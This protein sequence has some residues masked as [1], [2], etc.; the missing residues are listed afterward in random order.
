MLHN[1]YIQQGVHLKGGQA[2]QAGEVFQIPAGDVEAG[3][4]PG[5]ADVPFR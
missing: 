2:V 1:T 4:V 3:T 5:A